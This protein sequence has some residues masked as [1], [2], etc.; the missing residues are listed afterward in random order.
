VFVP[1]KPFLPSLMFGGK[2][3]TYPRVEHLKG[4]SLGWAPAL[5]ANNRQGWKGLPGTNAV[6]SYENTYTTAVKSFITLATWVVKLF[7]RHNLPMYKLECLSL[8]DLSSLLEYLL[9]R[10]EAS[11]YG[12]FLT[13]PANIRLFWKGC[14]D[15]HSSL[16]GPFINYD[17]KK[18]DNIGPS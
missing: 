8:A 18:F 9:F 14:K 13:L 11:L 3:I 6:A 1:G 10:L 5:P 7:F 17:R 4:A 12:K 2:A 16:F 15:K